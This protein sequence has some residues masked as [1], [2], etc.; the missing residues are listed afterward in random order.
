MKGKGAF[1]KDLGGKSVKELVEL[2]RTLRDK[3]HALKMKHAMRAVK[4]TSEIGQLTKDIA[5]VSTILT[6]KI[7][8]N[9]GGNRK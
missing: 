2:R 9:Y 8:S 4:K 7:K 3:K 1:I 5:R 6:L